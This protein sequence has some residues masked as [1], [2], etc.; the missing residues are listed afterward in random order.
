MITENNKTQ[1]E[2]SLSVSSKHLGKGGKVEFWECEGGGVSCPQ[3]IFSNPKG[4]ANAP[5]LNE[6]LPIL[7]FK[8]TSLSLK[9]R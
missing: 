2:K 6:T 3:C 8:S 9:N 1:K 7:K 4:G 5:P